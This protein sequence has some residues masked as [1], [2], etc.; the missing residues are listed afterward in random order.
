MS[1]LTPRVVPTRRAIARRS[2][3]KATAV[4]LGAIVLAPALAA[5]GM[6]PGQGGDKLIVWTDATFAPPS[7]DY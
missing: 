6:I 1:E 2:V 4:G 5:C 3:L 7:D